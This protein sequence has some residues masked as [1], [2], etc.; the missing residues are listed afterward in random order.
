MAHDIQISGDALKLLEEMGSI[1]FTE[2]H[3]TYY[4]LPYWFEKLPSGKLRMHL[5][6]RK[7]PQDLQEAI[8]RRRRK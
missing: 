2:N 5:L 7:L 6:D 8:M 4:F 3:K 1:I